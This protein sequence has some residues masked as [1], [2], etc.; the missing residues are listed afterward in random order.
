[1]AARIMN[2]LPLPI[3]NLTGRERSH[4]RLRG[5]GYMAAAVFVFSIMDALLKRMSTH[6][7]PL[8][9]SC[10]RC[11]SSWLFLLPPIAWQRT[12]PELRPSNALLHLFRAGLGI[13][14]LTGFVFAVHR[15]SLAQTYSLFL[16][17]PL[18]MTALSVPIHGEKVTG[19]RWAA[20]IVGLGG[21][22]V[23]LHPWGTGSFSMI[24]A[25]AAALATICYSISALTVRTLGRSNSSMSMVFWYLL[26]VSIGSGLL[27][28]A[29]WRPVPASDWGWLVGIGVTGALGQMWLTDAFRQ[30]PPSVVGPFEYTAILWAFAIDWI[31]WAASP[32]LSLIIGAGIVIASGIVVIVDEH[33]LSQL[34]LSPASPPP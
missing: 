20:I 4:E 3:G 13:G 2:R 16:A 32:S 17:A 24:A 23:I 15:L 7:G 1:M 33:R 27:A 22:L 18:L 25:S 12:W 10:L 21:V 11:I 28:V 8:Q 34:A 29:E 14:M 5:I 31:F 26:L 30:A 19:K 6:Y 9:I